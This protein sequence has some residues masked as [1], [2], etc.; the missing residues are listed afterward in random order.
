MAYI[1]SRK[2]PTAALRPVAPAALAAL[3]TLTLP[4]G[5]Q[6]TTPATTTS[7][8]TSSQATLPAV[9]VQG[10]QD[11]YKADSVS[12]PKYT[13]PLVDTPQTITVIKKELL[14]EQGAAS[15]TDA[16]RNTTGITFQMGENGNTATG[17]S[18]FMRG[19]DTQG[20][21][22]VDGIRDLGSVSRDMFNIEQV[23]VVKGPAGSDIGRGA[24]TGY[25]NLVSKAPFGENASSGTVSFGTASQKRLTAD[26]NRTLDTEGSTAVR[27]NLS[28]HHGGIAGRDEV[29]HKGWAFAPSIAFGLGSP[30]QVTLSY[31]HVNQR[32][33]PDGGLPTTGLPGYY[34]AALADRGGSGP[35]ADTSRYYGWSSDHDDVD[36]DMFTAKVEH[37][38]A[39]GITVSNIARWGRTRQ[40][41]VLTAPFSTTL[42]ASD[43]A[44][45]S[46]WQTRV[47]PQG[48]FQRNEIMANHTNVR[49]E[50]ELGG[51]KHRWSTGVEFAREEQLVRARA[52]VLDASNG[53]EVV[54]NGVAAY[55]AYANLYDPDMGRAFVPVE[56]TGAQTEG[57]IS[58]AAVYA[59]DTVSFSPQ[60]ELTGGLRFERY[61]VSYTSIPA[62]TAA[63]QTATTLDGHG[64]ELTGKLGLVYKPLPNG[65]VYAAVATSAKP[66]G[67]EFTLSE[68]TVNNPDFEPQ[69]ASTWELGTKWD[70]LD[71]RLALTAAV[72]HTTNRNDAVV[73]DATT[74][75]V[76]QVGKTK[77]DGVE[78]GVAGMVTP[79]W[80][81]SAGVSHIETE[82]V[83]GS[84]AAQAGAQI[85]YSPKWTAT[86]WSSYRLPFGLTLGGGARYVG[87][88]ARQTTNVAATATTNFPEIPAY[89]VFDAMAAYDLSKNLSLQLNIYNLTDKFYLARVN[90]A[91]NRYTL[92]TPRSALVTASYRF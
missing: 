60:W 52:A 21:I 88:Q 42:I 55:Q 11:G 17:D 91:G 48:K 12:S 58:T 3:A 80:Q 35:K 61:A 67:S 7:T 92:G 19:F 75:E 87:T 16:L 53:I 68:T 27:L 77:V 72:F 51:L 39:H 33:R 79:A 37:R 24:P 56:P 71:N 50:H 30:T 15:L 9:R 49:G 10:S 31:L 59:F 36:A 22:F 5:A 45:P 86:L 29:L 78:L 89:T 34:A 65:S 23:E 83:E 41:L 76:S 44:D 70:L 4:V 47:L 73:T 28:G 62:L 43:L 6:T 46:S 90:N 66:P 38:A 57:R 1:R 8:N 13:A 63:D 84:T 18:V 2:H 74:G 64:N 14:Q 82:I 32:N 40:D 85:R 69:K 25:I 20:S 54:T 26:L 81:V